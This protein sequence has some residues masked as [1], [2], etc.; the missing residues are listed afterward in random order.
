MQ[1]YILRRLA[2]MVFVILGMTVI[3]FVISHLIPANPALLAAGEGADASIVAAIRAEYGLD[4]PLP[5]Q[6]WL[7]LKGLFQGNLGRS[8]LTGRPVLDDI[9][10]R[11]PATLELALASTVVALVLGVSMG[12]LSALS[13]DRIID[14]AIRLFS[15]IWVGMAEFWLALMLQI[16][17]YGK[18]SWLPFGGRTAVQV[19]SPPHITGLFTVD[20]LLSLRFGLLADVLVHLILPVTALALHRMAEL[21]RMTRSSMLEVLG[22]DYIRTARSKGLAERSVIVVHALKNAALPIIT[23]VGIQFGYALGGTV[24]IEAIFQWPGMGRYAV[25]SIQ[26]VDFQPIM[27]VAVVISAV[28][29]LVNLFVDVLYTFAD[30]RIRY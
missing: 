3:V 5:E 9:K 20:A 22:A 13:Q 24:L 18:L 2:W 8:I 10:E 19:A 15:I 6:Y 25:Q 12:I 30:P 28:F 21:A 4:R 14:N 11:F 29:V 1:A 27:G 16:V 7:F 17:F 23:V 26:N